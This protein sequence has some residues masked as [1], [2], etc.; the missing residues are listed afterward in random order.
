MKLVRDISASPELFIAAQ[1]AAF[2]ARRPMGLPDLESVIFPRVMQLP[3]PVLLEEADKFLSA[4]YP[5]KPLRVFDLNTAFTILRETR[6][7]DTPPPEEQGELEQF[8][9]IPDPFPKALVDETR[10]WLATKFEA[11]AVW[12]ADYLLQLAR[13]DG[14]SEPAQRC[15]VFILYQSFAQSENTFD[16]MAARKSGAEFILDFVRGDNIEFFRKDSQ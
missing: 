7:D 12:Q 13:D 11:G 14:L 9:A 4:L 6:T 5:P 1:K 3:A 16:G 8:V 10:N 2:R 15:L